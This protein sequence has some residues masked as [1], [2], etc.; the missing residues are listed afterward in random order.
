M[1]TTRLWT[2]EDVAAMPE[3]FVHAELWH[4]EIHT[5]SPTGAEHGG[6]ALAIGSM[7][8]QFVRSQRIGHVV[9]TDVGF[10]LARNPD[11]LLAPDVAVIPGFDLPLPRGFSTIIPLLVVEV[12]SS[13]ESAID[14]ERKIDL[15]RNAGVPLIW[16]VY[17][18]TRSVRVDEGAKAIHFVNLSGALDGGDVLPGMPPLPLAEI[19]E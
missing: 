2:A 13:S 16:T 10:L 17:P 9:G 4:G 19:F 8:R 12:I 18:E 15:Y 14:V 3:S 11:L 7:L 6:I 5:M 1:T